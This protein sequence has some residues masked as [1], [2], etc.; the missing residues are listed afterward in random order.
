MNHQ[1]Q[2]TVLLMKTV[3]GF[4]MGASGEA[5]NPSHQQK[6]MSS[7]DLYKFRDRF[8][9]PISDEQVAQLELVRP[10]ES[11]EEMQ[12]IRE[13]RGKLGGC[14]PMRLQRGDELKAPELST[15]ERLLKDSGDR[16]MSTTQALVQAMTMLT[17]TRN[18][19]HAW[20]Q[21][22]LTRPGLSGWRGCS[23]KLGSMLT[24]DRSMSRLTVIN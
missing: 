19:A 20:Y 15:F 13:R 6:K 7:D 12:Y 23:A 10:D 16:E 18:L 24:K 9:L 5:A 1:G 3:K 22:F 14:L 8:S 17:R 2:P 11:T 21:L 4:G